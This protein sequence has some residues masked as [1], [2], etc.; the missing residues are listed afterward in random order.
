VTKTVCPY[1]LWPSPITPE[2]LSRGKRLAEVGWDADGLILVWLEERSDRGVLVCVNN[3]G[4]AP[5][6]LTNTLSV[7]AKVGYGGGEFT[8]GHGYVYFAEQS[9][10][11]YR[12]S[13]A[14][15]T[16]KPLLEAFGY[17][18]SPCL[19]PDGAWLVYIHSYEGTDIIAIVDSE[20]KQWPQKLA[21]GADF[22]M[23]PCWH[24]SGKWLTWIEWDH[25]Q[26]PW[27]GTRLMLA[28]VVTENGQ[29]PRLLKLS[30]IT[31]DTHTGIFQP[32]FSP[33]GMLIA[34]I[35]DQNGWSNLWIYDVNQKTC[36]CLIKEPADLGVPA[37]T[38]G[39][40]TFGFSPNGQHIYFLQ[41]ERG[42][43][44]TGSVEIATGK[45]ST[46][47]ALSDYESFAQ[48]AISPTTSTIAVIGSAGTTPPQILTYTPNA[49]IKIH[50]QA[51]DEP[52]AAERLSQP[53]P[54]EW[55]SP[56]G[57]TIYGI[58]YPPTNP[59]F[60]GNDRPPAIIQI[61]GG[62]TG[63]RDMSFSSTN[64]FF[65]TRGYAVLEVNYRGST[66]YGKAYRQALNGK[67][68][69]YDVEDAV[70]G[71]QHLLDCSLAHPERLVIMGGSAGGYTVLRTL[72]TWPGFFKAGVCLYGIS[73]LFTLDAE[74]HKFESHYL[75]SLVGPLPKANAIYQERSPIFSVEK[76]RDSIAIFQGEEDR[77]VPKDQAELMV[78]ALKQH[79]V[80]YEYHLYKGE[81]HGWR[82]AETITKFYTAVE[83]FLKQHVVSSQS[84]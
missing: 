59:D 13:V 29:C 23:Q 33:D 7:R 53:K 54:I 73:N 55:A 15:G 62:P 74:T 49:E 48:L 50:T 52:I 61:H 84:L 64:Q 43:W 20:G 80:P 82:K 36:R 58:Y 22:Y 79:G 75:K 1:G 17:A 78:N 32:T 37:W 35:S 41:N 45:I 47:T 76:I 21:T 3:N 60:E 39:R 24:P 30:V 28:H 38:H 12:Q 9:G 68:G 4:Q 26:M 10:R 42:R 2:Y 18:T 81:G 56:S 83:A 14:S 25:P 66:G 57:G 44:K 40:R 63:Q 46:L 11:L 72:T 77:V 69:I 16:A 51:I 67:W 31:G 70:S 19:S 6:E 8:V 71:A 65:A 5:R 27:D 34:Y